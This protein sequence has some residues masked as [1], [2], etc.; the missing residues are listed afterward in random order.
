M[1]APEPAASF[2]SPS[3]E[4]TEAAGARLGAALPPGA[5]VALVGELGAG[6]T[7]F[8]RGLAR[9]LGVEGPVTSPS[10]ALMTEYEGRLPLYHFDAWM[11]GREAALLADGAEEYLDGPGVAAVEWADRVTDHLPAPR[12]EV[13]LWHLAEDARG[14]AVRVVTRSPGAAARARTAALEA[15][16]RALEGTPGLE[17]LPEGA[18]IP[19]AG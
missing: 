2:R 10:Y 5:L 17:P 18:G 19:D 4:V 9:G 3:P 16:R 11:R 7:A 12:L 8:V 15:A 1:A 13:R 14:L 6:K